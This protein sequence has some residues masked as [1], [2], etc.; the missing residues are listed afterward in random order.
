MDV[1][2][3]LT[4]LEESS[5]NIQGATLARDLARKTFEAEQR[6]YDLGAST[7]FFVLD[8]QQ[9]LSDA[10]S[11]LLQALISFCKAVISVERATGSLLEDNHVVLQQALGG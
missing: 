2:K 9:R 7:T 6:K 10:E 3:A 11:Q 5:M 1:R 4:S 8:A